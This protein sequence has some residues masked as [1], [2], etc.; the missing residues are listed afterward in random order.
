MHILWPRR[1]KATLKQE[2]IGVILGCGN[3]HEC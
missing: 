2:E 1:L 3:L